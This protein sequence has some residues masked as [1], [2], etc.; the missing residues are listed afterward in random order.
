MTT[1]TTVMVAAA[2]ESDD[3]VIGPMPASVPA[4]APAHQGAQAFM[5]REE[6]QR[7]AAAQEETK[8]SKPTAR[9]D[10]MLT[11]PSP[12][13]RGAAPPGV[14][15]AR[16]FQQATSRAWRAGPDD[17]AEAHRLWTE[18]PEQK[19]ER[20][21][22]GAEPSVDPGWEREAL[23][24]ERVAARDAA[25]RAQV[26]SHNKERSKSLLDEHKN[27]RLDEL[28][29]REEPRMRHDETRHR[30]RH[31]SSERREHRHRH[32]TEHR[33]RHEHRSH[34]SHGHHRER[35][36]VRKT[37]AQREEED[38]ERYGEY[39]SPLFDKDKVL[40]KGSRLMD[41]RA[42]SRSIA[43]ATQLSSRFATG[44]SGAFL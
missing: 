4:P 16:G 37:R 33:S 34:R 17:P 28:R 44:S 39:A 3:E 29:R 23:E 8:A 5:E 31:E 15:R 40:G 6:R 19:R 7:Q 36:P 35:S 42:R 18:T 27:R 12:A 38:R 10:W 21:Q 43:D 41:E 32:R 30:S 22:R 13:D 1:S 24:K 26:Q 25:L 14:L 20:L 11:M 2:D 9:P